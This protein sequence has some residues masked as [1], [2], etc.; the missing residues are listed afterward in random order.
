MPGPL[1]LGTPELGPLQSVHCIECHLKC[2]GASRGRFPRRWA[3]QTAQLAAAIVRSST[4]SKTTMRG[5]IKKV[6]NSSVPSP[7][8]A[9]STEQAHLQPSLLSTTS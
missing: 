4:I 7:V 9:K 3:R 1:N 5:W 2:I 8:V 6:F